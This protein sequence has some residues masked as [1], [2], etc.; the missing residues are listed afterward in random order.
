MFYSLKSPMRTKVNC[1][2]V[3]LTLFLQGRNDNGGHTIDHF[4][5]LKV[6]SQEVS[7]ASELNEKLFLV[8][9]YSPVW[10]EQRYLSIRGSV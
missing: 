8:R 1:D 6:I 3:S 5:L 7:E 10:P 4:L 9:F 2:P